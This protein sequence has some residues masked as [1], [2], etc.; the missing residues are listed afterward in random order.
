MDPGYNDDPKSQMSNFIQENVN[1]SK[2][3]KVENKKVIIGPGM[4]KQ[5][6]AV[7]A[8][9]QQSNDFLSLDLLG[10]STPAQL[11]IPQTNQTSQGQLSFE[12]MMGGINLNGSSPS[13]SSNSNPNSNFLI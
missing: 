10:G 9:A 12:D 6:P 13:P 4:V 7:V 1:I 2:S 5:K 3:K 8:Q 11:P